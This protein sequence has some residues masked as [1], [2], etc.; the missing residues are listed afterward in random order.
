MTKV[1]TTTKPGLLSQATY[2]NQPEE[3]IDLNIR[4]KNSKTFKRKHRGENLHDFGFC[5]DF[6]N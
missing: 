5:Q 6:L 1:T 3:A 2:K 4:A